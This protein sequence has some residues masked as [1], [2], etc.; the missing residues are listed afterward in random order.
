ML[1]CI[2]LKG[3]EMK[4]CMFVFFK[5]G[6]PDPEEAVLLSGIRDVGFPVSSLRRNKYFEITLDDMP[7]TKAGPL[8][9][10][11]GKKLLANPVIEDF[12]LELDAQEIERQKAEML[13]AINALAGEYGLKAEF[14]GDAHSVGVQG[15]ARTY[16]PVVVLMGPHPGDDKLAELGSKIWNS[17]HINRVTFDITSL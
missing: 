5:P 4:A 6:V 2:D 14:L 13:V 7:F 12:R 9:E 15:D 10:E 8:L 11:M 16:T 17:V 1:H 3:G